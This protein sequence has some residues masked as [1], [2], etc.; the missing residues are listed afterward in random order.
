MQKWLHFNANLARVVVCISFSDK[1]IGR[2]YCV[3]TALIRWKPN[4]WKEKP[5]KPCPKRAQPQGGC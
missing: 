5:R 2:G 1:E 4:G 3:D